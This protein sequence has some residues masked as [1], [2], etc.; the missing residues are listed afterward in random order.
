MDEL[1]DA[2][3]RRQQDIVSEVKNYFTANVSSI[4]ETERNLSR[5]MQGIT[6]FSRIESKEKTQDITIQLF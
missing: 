3:R 4:I 6:Q 2:L 5:V 1:M